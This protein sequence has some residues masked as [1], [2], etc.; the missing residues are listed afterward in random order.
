MY[1][2]QNFK[3]QGGDKLQAFTELA[4]LNRQGMTSNISVTSTDIYEP[5]E[6]F[7][8]MQD[9][10][11]QAVPRDI[12]DD[13][14][15]DVSLCAKTCW[16]PDILHSIPESFKKS[17]TAP[18]NDIEIEAEKKRVR[19][20]V[21]LIHDAVRELEEDDLD[22]SHWIWHHKLFYDWMKSIVA[23]ADR[24]ELRAGSDKWTTTTQGM[25][26]F[27]YDELDA[28]SPTDQMLVRIG[29]NL[30]AILRGE[31][32][33][34]EL[35]MEDNLLN[36]HYGDQSASA[37]RILDN[38]RTILELHAMKDPGAK[39]L[40]IGGGTGG[41]TKVALEAFDA[42]ARKE[43][44]EGSLIGNYTFTDVS[45]GFFA[46]ARERFAA[47]EGVMDFKQL[48]IDEDP[49]TQVSEFLY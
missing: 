33:T 21:Y 30:A 8:Q 46:A 6:S 7:F 49:T 22:T 2:P 44:L 27:L 32:T 19:A 39:I 43:G 38:A 26:Q 10:F 29:Q 34:L 23:S 20:A 4:R 9:F 42:R 12:E 36:K 31:V 3:R 13:T 48:D 1:I 11:C 47:W 16:V 14:S 15:E 5:K 18:M 24:G 25:R 17:L 45:Q 37:L 41:G 28:A 35:M 40:E